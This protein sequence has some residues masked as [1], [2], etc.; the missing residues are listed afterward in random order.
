MFYRQL[1]FMLLIVVLGTGPAPARQAL[2]DDS[3]KERAKRAAEPAPANEEPA[4]RLE[5]F[6]ARKNVLLI[7]DAFA[8]GTVPGQQGYEVRVEALVV[9][10]A[11]EA[12]KVYGLSLIRLAGRAGAGERSIEA[13]RFVDFDE[14]AALQ[15]ALEYLAKVAGESAPEGSVTARPAA[16]GEESGLSGSTEFSLQTR[17]GLKTGMLQIGRQQTGFIQFAATDNTVVFGI[18]A[19]SRFRNLVA[20]ARSRLVA[21]GAR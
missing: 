14:I 8:V 21:L 15:N 6:M 7:K 5:K 10:A 17:G 1:I 18:G 12:A 19:L 9:S 16:P 2:K 20:Q 13:V 11:G 4:T 3:E